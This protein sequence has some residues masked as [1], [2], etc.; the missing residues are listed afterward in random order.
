MVQDQ[1]KLEQEKLQAVVQVQLLDKKDEIASY[2]AGFFVTKTG[3]L[4]TSFH[5]LQPF[6][7]DKN[8]RLKILPRNYTRTLGDVEIVACQD[9]RKIDLCLLKVNDYQPAAYLVP[10]KITFALGHQG[11]FIGHCGGRDFR[12]VKGK[13]KAVYKDIYEFVTAI[14]ILDEYH[15][16]RNFKVEMVQ[17]DVEHCGGDSGGPLFGEQGE[18][19]GVTQEWININGSAEKF[20]LFISANEVADY[21]EKYKNNPSVKVPKDRMYIVDFKAR[22][23]EMMQLK[24]QATLPKAKP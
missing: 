17:M 16:D 1:A 20:Y 6:L 14:K 10:A 8:L 2:A 7:Q 3:Y 19:W 9:D 4:L 12:V 22:Y 21:F 24:K 23:D 13:L 15:P 18:L 5:V 11:T